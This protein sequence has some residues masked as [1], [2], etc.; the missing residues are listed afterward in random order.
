MTRMTR[1]V[2]V[3]ETNEVIF[4][5][6]NEYVGKQVEMIAYIIQDT[7]TDLQKQKDI[8]FTDFGLQMPEN[9]KFDREEANA[10]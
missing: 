6:P 2:L 1:T 10:R 7:Q 5:L 3:P 8:S 9:Y 4:P